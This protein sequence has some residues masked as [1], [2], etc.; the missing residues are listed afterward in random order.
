MFVS[1]ALAYIFVR[2]RAFFAAF[3]MAIG[4]MFVVVV[5]G[6]VSQLWGEFTYGGKRCKL[7]AILMTLLMTTLIT[8]E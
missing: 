4:T 6:I 2:M 3:D 5:M 7:V 8:E 1:F